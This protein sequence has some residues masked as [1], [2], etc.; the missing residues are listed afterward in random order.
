M[1]TNCQPLPPIY[2]V[3]GSAQPLTRVSRNVAP[4]SAGRRQ[5]AASI[6]WLSA[7]LT[8]RL[9]F[10]VGCDCSSGLQA[11]PR[12]IPELAM[13]RR[14]ELSAEI[15]V[16]LRDLSAFWG[17]ASVCAWQAANDRLKEYPNNVDEYVESGA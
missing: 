5:Q 14:A 17:P 3:L 1:W 15:Q 4:V 12:Y 9:R 13:T 7:R 10:P 2:E 8:R 11:L 16:N 6:C